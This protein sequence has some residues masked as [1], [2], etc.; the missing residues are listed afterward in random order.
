[1]SIS[2]W[3]LSTPCTSSGSITREV[4]FNVSITSLGSRGSVCLGF[5]PWLSLDTQCTQLL[6]HLLQVLGTQDGFLSSCCAWPPN[7]EKSVDSSKQDSSLS[8]KSYPRN[9]NCSSVCKA[10]M[11]QLLNLIQ[12]REMKCFAQIMFFLTNDLCIKIMVFILHFYISE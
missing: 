11:L 8:A 7:S 1:M 9:W 4:T 12:T 5:Y 2:S 3:Y 6:Q 10:D